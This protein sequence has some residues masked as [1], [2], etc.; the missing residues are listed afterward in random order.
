MRVVLSPPSSLA[1]RASEV[2]R[3]CG[4]HPEAGA[5][6]EKRLQDG[7]TPLHWQAP[8]GQRRGS[9]ALERGRDP[10]ARGIPTL[11]GRSS[12]GVSEQ[13][14]HDAAEIEVGILS[15]PLQNGTLRELLHAGEG[16][17]GPLAALRHEA[18]GG[19]LAPVH[20]PL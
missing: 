5:A 20:A 19:P 9:I 7:V 12:L 6:S 15:E 1:E 11:P 4:V 8:G 14:V 17:E 18:L 16:H 10:H 13:A 2:L 3:R